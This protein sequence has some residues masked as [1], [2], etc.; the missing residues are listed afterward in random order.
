MKPVVELDKNILRVF[1]GGCW[2]DS[3][4]FARVAYRAEGPA[5][6]HRNDLGFRLFEGMR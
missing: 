2:H 4:R 6:Y 3:V 1:R 5:S